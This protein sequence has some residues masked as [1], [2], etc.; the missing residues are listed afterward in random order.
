LGKSLV[1]A[2]AVLEKLPRVKLAAPLACAHTV[3]EHYAALATE[4]KEVS[5][6]TSTALHDWLVC[7]SGCLVVGAA[8][9]FSRFRG[10]LVCSVL[11]MFVS[12]ISDGYLHAAGHGQRF[13][14]PRALQALC[15]AVHYAVGQSPYGKGGFYYYYPTVTRPWQTT[16]F[17][18]HTETNTRDDWEHTQLY[19]FES[20][21]RKV[22]L[23]LLRQ[24]PTP[25]VAA[26]CAA[27]L[28]FFASSASDSARRLALLLPYLAAFA[29]RVLPQLRKTAQLVRALGEDK[30]RPEHPAVKMA[31]WA[32]HLL[33]GADGP[34]LLMWA[35]CTPLQASLYPLLGMLAFELL[36]TPVLGL[37]Q[38][39]TWNEVRE[40]AEGESLVPK[41]VPWDVQQVLTSADC[42]CTS[43]LMRAYDALCMHADTYQTTH[44]LFP[45]VHWAHM[46]ALQPLVARWCK[47]H[48]H[49]YATVTDAQ[50]LKDFYQGK[51]EKGAKLN[52][53]RRRAA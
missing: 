18:H 13:M 37:T 12:R 52:S 17:G 15:T 2:T 25:I 22:L 43:A 31:A 20:S 10:S 47:E 53:R 3:S 38:H 35:T 42:V 29:W 46:P 23:S 48:G 28:A 7:V 40:T 8:I 49:P 34:G 1:R 41:G 14:I 4:V 9:W 5:L 51:W 32:A 24:D 50:A 16:H 27:F 11:M 44:H 26:A 33:V 30:R 19:D 36:W 6:R 39:S 21:A 45:A